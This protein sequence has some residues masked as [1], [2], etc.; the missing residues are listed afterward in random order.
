MASEDPEAGGR[1]DPFVE[2]REPEPAERP[3]AKHA[4]DQ[5]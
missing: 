4:A 2:V 5:R 1:V 3:E